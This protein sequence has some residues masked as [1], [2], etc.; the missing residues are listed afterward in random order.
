MGFKVSH[1][2]ISSSHLS[3]DILWTIEN[4]TQ[5]GQDLLH[6][7]PKIVGFFDFGLTNSC[8]QMW[9]VTQ[10][11]QDFFI[12]CYQGVI[13]EGQSYASICLKVHPSLSDISKI[14]ITIVCRLRHKAVIANMTHL[15]VDL[16][17]FR[18][19]LLEIFKSVKI[20]LVVTAKLIDVFT[21]LFNGTQEILTVLV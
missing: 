12:C 13:K 11:V 18:K 20:A 6:I 10:T 8:R 16:F 9:Q 21:R 3:I 5:I 4:F 2:K 7:S 1:F 15:N 17:Q 14:F 19:G